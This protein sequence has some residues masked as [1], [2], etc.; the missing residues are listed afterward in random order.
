MTSSTTVQEVE[1]APLRDPNKVY[2]WAGGVLYLAAI[3]LCAVAISIHPVASAPMST[4]TVVWGILILAAFIGVEVFPLQVEVARNTTLITLSEVPLVFGLLLLPLPWAV[5]LPVIACLLVFWIRRDKLRH[6]VINSGFVFLETAVAAAGVVAAQLILG[7]SDDVAML[8][9]ML[10]VPLGTLLTAVIVGELHL[11][12]DGRRE[13]FIRNAV[14]SIATSGI[15][16]ILALA[17]WMLLAQ[18]TIPG[19]VGCIGT[20]LAGGIGY[21]AYARVLGRQHDYQRFAA[22]SRQIP[23]LAPDFA[24]WPE[25]LEQVREQFNAQVAIFTPSPVWDDATPLVIAAPGAPSTVPLPDE[26]DD[27]LIPHAPVLALSSTPGTFDAALEQRQ[28]RHVLL[29]RLETEHVFLGHI[30]VRDRRT[31]WGSYRSD[32]LQILGDVARQI[33]AQWILGQTA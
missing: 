32:D 5:A 3:A 4:L 17:C 24:R 23:D 12:T 22:I 8:G 28:A 1:D 20:L 29:V 14:R 27:L 13:P 2:L 18:R 11:L 15:V 31:R 26:K 9:I 6:V 25:L 16:T 19:M 30:E 33:T 21:T 10:A 7:P